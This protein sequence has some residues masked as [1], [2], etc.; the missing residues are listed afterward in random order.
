MA[1]CLPEQLRRL[2]DRIQQEEMSL[3]LE[4]MAKA[5]MQEGAEEADDP[6]KETEREETI[7]VLLRSLRIHMCLDLIGQG[8]RECVDVFRED[9]KK[10]IGSLEFLEGVWKANNE[11]LCDAVDILLLPDPGKRKDLIRL[12]D[13]PT[14]LKIKKQKPLRFA[15]LDC[16]MKMAEYCLQTGRKEE[17]CAMMSNLISLS[18]ERNADHLKKHRVVTI[19][20]LRYLVDNDR[21]LT[22]Q[23]CDEQKQYFLDVADIHSCE[24]CWFYGLALANENRLEE[25]VSM[26]KRC[27]DFCMEVQGETS[28]I[29]ARAG[30]VYY[31][32]LLVMEASAEA[33]AYLWDA[34]RKTEAGFYSGMDQTAAYTAATIRSTLLRYRMD[35]QKMEGLLPELEKFLEYCVAEADTN[36]NP[37]LTI[38]HAENM[39]SGYYLEMGDYLQAADH[40][41]NAL[42]AVPGN[43]LPAIPSD[44]LLYTNLLQ[45]YTALNDTERMRFYIQ[46]L[47]DLSD[48]FQ[49]DEY[50]MSRAALIVN[51]ASKKLVI[52][53]ESIQ[54]DLEYL[55]DLH[56]NLADLDAEVS[57]SVMENIT[58][59]QWL[60]DICSGVL[61]SG[62][63]GKADLV[64][65]RDIVTYFRDRPKI[66]PFND[67]QKLTCNILM[68]QIEW[69]LGSG[70]DL[71]Y[72][73]KG[74]Q[75]ARNISASRE[76]SIAILRF[77]AVVYY[78]HNRIHEAISL[79][80]MVLSGITSAWQKAT[81]YLNDHRICEVLAF[82]Q[83]HFNICYAVMC[84]YADSAQLY[85][86][87]L[88]FKNLPALV[89]RERNR[90]L[91]LAPV[92]DD[93][94]N[95][96]FALQD[97]LAAAEL[98]DSL[99]GT[100]TARQVAEK[101]ERKEAEFAASFPQNLYFTEIS[102]D[103]VCRKLPDHAAIVEYYFA[104]EETAL[105]GKPIGAEDWALDVFITARRDHSPQLNHLRISRGD[106]ILEQAA[107]YIDILQNPGDVSASTRKELLSGQLYGS[108]IAPVLPFLDGITDVY[109]AP[110][111][112][113]CNLPFEIL[114]G[115]NADMLQEKFRVCRVVC[116]R[117]ILFYDDNES[118]GGNFILGD[119][120]YESQRGERTG[121]H[122]RG[123]QMHLEPVPD[124]PFSGIEAERIGRRC[125]SGVFSGE[126]ATKY[127]LQDALPCRLIHLATHGVFDDQLETDS[128]YA[129]HLVFAGY[130][131][132]VTSKTVSS[133]C[134]NGILT[135][136]EISR[137]DLKKTELVVLSACRSGLGDTSYG[138]VRGLLSAF[139]AAGARWVISHMWQADD[140]TTPILMDAFY[141]AY[142]NRGLEVPDAL[143]YAKDYLRHVTVG[144][145]RQN[146]WLDL[147]ADARFPEEVREAVADLRLWNPEE[148][149]FADE[150][151]WGGFTVHKSR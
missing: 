40:S 125:G 60:L 143:Q 37:D 106:I 52:D 134:G 139:S 145:L 124:L 33:E 9:W 47:V 3:V 123:G 17:L 133:H 4:K 114:R 58:F 79:I 136:D 99:N 67:T 74:L 64:K 100:D 25:A 73:E 84:T 8:H 86:R 82:I 137:M 61:D 71:E 150:F 85:E 93:L 10:I 55:R 62:T 101:L 12:L 45:I 36:Q 81:A 89:G 122:L 13:L 28:W 107:E 5:I 57:E 69:Q 90:L 34:L 141:H 126:H 46:K 14:R 121:S 95:Q 66:Y 151:Y 26:M 54:E 128:L 96:I 65:I 53:Q 116:G 146:G 109:L 20:S 48:L 105:S 50:V 63:T 30:S 68:A 113:L 80:G 27:Y 102:F 1:E 112:Q 41:L 97:Q 24:F 92:D 2:S 149:P 11:L 138:S 117:D 129:S 75:Y 144:E 131:K 39:L 91:R 135:A 43:N 6:R 31:G 115:E 142:L 70:K 119:P 98:N 130:N 51:T 147:P 108:L 35:R 22:C 132:W 38:R 18:E 118:A 72:L 19:N 59:C 88:Q 44:V 78:T 7:S 23:I 16:G 42:H 94:K 83:L 76:V 15:V 120:N 104:L 140:F 49:D 127:A 56:S 32:R 110:D 87:I 77:A 103:R 111:D 148:T 21:K 29:G